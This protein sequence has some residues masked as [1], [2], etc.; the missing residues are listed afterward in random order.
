V[1]IRWIGLP[2][3]GDSLRMGVLGIL[4]SEDGRH[5]GSGLSCCIARIQCLLLE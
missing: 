4:G 5:G 2:F 3:A 1:G